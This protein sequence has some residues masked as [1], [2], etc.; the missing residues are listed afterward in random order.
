MKYIIDPI[1]LFICIGDYCHTSVSRRS[2]CGRLRRAV[3]GGRRSQEEEEP[4]RGGGGGGDPQ[5][6]DILLFW[7]IIKGPFTVC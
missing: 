5:L 6:R 2:R 1:T 3:A 4:G 7:L